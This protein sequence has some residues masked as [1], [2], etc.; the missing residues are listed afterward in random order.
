M[1]EAKKQAQGAEIVMEGL[2][3]LEGQVDEEKMEINSIACK[4]EEKDDGTIM[5]S[6]KDERRNG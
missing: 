6:N 4:L 5:W 3:L 2:A 1:E